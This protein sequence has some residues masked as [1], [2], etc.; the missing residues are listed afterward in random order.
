MNSSEKQ[1][2]STSPDDT[3]RSKLLRA[4]ITLRSDKYFLL[5]KYNKNTN[6][7]LNFNNNNS[8][9]LWEIIQFIAEADFATRSVSVSDIYLSLGISKS[10]A[11]RCMKLLESANI[12]LKSR[13]R[14]DRRRAVITLSDDF[15]AEF[16]NRLDKIILELRGIGA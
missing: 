8:I 4:F 14:N 12:L 3:E 10:T 16:S 7:Y 2:G 15:R 5:E 11:I 6:K 9:L 1:S 13:D